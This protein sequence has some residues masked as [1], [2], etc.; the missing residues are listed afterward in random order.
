[1]NGGTGPG[2]TS[3]NFGF[4]NRYDAALV[5]VAGLAERYFPDIPITCL[6]KL[7]QF[8]QPLAQQLAARAGVFTGVDKGQSELLGRLKRDT[9]YPRAVIDLF[10]DL[11]R[12]GNDAVHQHRGDHATALT[13]LK[14]ARQLA[15]WFHRTFGERASRAGPFQP[16]RSPPD[17]AG[18][19]RDELERLRAEHTAS[20]SAADAAARAA[21]NAEVARRSAEVHTQAKADEQALWEALATETEARLLA[22]HEELARV[23]AAAVAQPAALQ[24]IVGAATEAAQAIDLDEQAIRTLIDGRLATGA[25]KSLS[26]SFRRGQ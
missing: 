7:W 22:L 17:P 14:V 1:M 3:I 21:A 12:G 8:G 20:L 25:T 26:T 2:I 6:M 11:R 24:L 23:Q 5:Q 16:P 9:A 18:P 15:V 19:L 13:G 10:H 4:L